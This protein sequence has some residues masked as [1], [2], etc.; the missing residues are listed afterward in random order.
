M[1][2]VEIYSPYIYSIKYDGQE[3]NEFDRLFAEW[4]DIEYIMDFLEKNKSFLKATVWYRTPEPESAV[5]QVLNET[6]ALE[7]L[8]DELAENTENGR[9]PDFDSHF[10][11]L[12]GKYKFELNYQPMKSY[13]NGRPPLLRIYAIKMDKNTYLITGG[14]IKLS[15]TIQNS[16][17]LKEH[18]LQDI[19]RVRGWLKANGIL[20]SD[21]MNN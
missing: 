11:Y 13:S 6:E 10:H 14:G 12:E 16:P 5:R 18:V 7:L 9:Q 2:I 3:E 15:D 8:F 4:S 19:D 17:G 21:D 20:D 1:E